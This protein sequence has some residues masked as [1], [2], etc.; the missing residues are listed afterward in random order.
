MAH[1]CWSLIAAPLICQPR[2]YLHEL[3]NLWGGNMFVLKYTKWLR[4]FH[5]H[6]NKSRTAWLGPLIHQKG[7]I[8]FSMEALGMEEGTKVDKGV[9]CALLIG[10]LIYD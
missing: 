8:S 6:F 7:H 9:G 5:G 1:G 4:G 2:Q 3:V 10:R